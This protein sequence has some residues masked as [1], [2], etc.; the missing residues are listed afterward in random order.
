MQLERAPDDMSA[1]RV[2]AH[3]QV[4]WSYRQVARACRR[5]TGLPARSAGSPASNAEAPAK[6]RG[7]QPSPFASACPG[8]RV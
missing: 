8:G 2:R 5:G 3:Q 7:G 6:R 1:A 4:A